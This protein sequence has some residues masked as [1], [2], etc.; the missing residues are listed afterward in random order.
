MVQD[1]ATPLVIKLPA[2]EVRVVGVDVPPGTIDLPFP[3]GLRVRW[4][5][6]GGVGRLWCPEC[7]MISREGRH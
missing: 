6:Q 1:W 5:V 3:D 2:I 7:P 4:T